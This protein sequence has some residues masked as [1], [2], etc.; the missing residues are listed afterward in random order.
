MFVDF[1]PYPFY[2]HYFNLNYS[3]LKAIK[4]NE[5]KKQQCYLFVVLIF[6]CE[7]LFAFHLDFFFRIKK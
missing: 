4:I 3:T 5:S 1:L 6:I 2:H 7:N